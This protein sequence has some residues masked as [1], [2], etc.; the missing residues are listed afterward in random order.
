[1]TKFQY[2]ENNYYVWGWENKENLKWPK[3]LDTPFKLS[4][5]KIN[6]NLLPFREECIIAA[7]KIAKNSSKEL[8][9]MISGGMDSQI[10]FLSFIEAGINF[11]P[12][13]VNL[14]DTNGNIIN[15]HDTSAAFELCS[16]FN[17]KPKVTTFNWNSAL[18]WIKTQNSNYVYNTFAVPFTHYFTDKYKNNCLIFG[19][20]PIDRCFY[21]PSIE[22]NDLLYVEHCA[23]LTQYAIDND[24]EAIN[25]FYYTPELFL[26]HWVDDSLKYFKKAIKTLKC[27]MDHYINNNNLDWQSGSHHLSQKFLND[28]WKPLF[29]VHHWPEIIQ[30]VKYHGYENAWKFEKEIVKKYMAELSI[31][32]NPLLKKHS[33]L[34][35][36]ND[37][38]Q[39]MVNKNETLKFL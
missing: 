21:I 38:E 22:Q 19:G 6:R 34:I 8:L 20:T 11:T 30:R 18:E 16:R 7:K 14:T 32:N 37:L 29:Y 4:I 36:I 2:T 33:I 15:G 27:S 5:E 26:S 13:I 23:Q 1:M 10:I 31:P 24:L 28:W 35:K 25:F 17:K 3:I 9:P 39:Y 12:L